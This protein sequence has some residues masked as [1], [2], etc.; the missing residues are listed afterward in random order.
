MACS[1]PE[2]LVPSTLNR[3]MKLAAVFLF[4]VVGAVGSIK[5]WSHLNSQ[6]STDDA[7]IDGHIHPVNARVSGTIVWVNPKVDDTRFVEAGTVLARLDNNDYTPSVDRLKGNVEAGEAQLESAKLALPI[8]RAAALSRFSSAQAAILEAQSDLASA[9]AGEQA[10]EALVVQ[11][12]ASFLRAESDRTR[13]EQLVSAHEISRS[14]YDQRRTDSKVFG[15]QFAAAKS[16]LAA[17]SQKIQAAEQHIAE[18]EGDLQAAATAPEVIATSQSS[19]NRVA[20]ELKRDEAS[21]HDAELN[22]SYTE[23]LAPV[24]GIVGRKQIEAGQRIAAGQLLLNLVPTNDLW[25]IANFKETQLRHMAIGSPAKI[26]VDSYGSVLDGTVE[27][28]G[29]ATGSKYSLIAPEN[30]TGNYVKV[31]QRIPVRIHITTPLDSL[32]PML[33]GMSVEVSVQRQ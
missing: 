4:L 25:V 6:I 8:T 30:A 22:L 17:A 31:L 23:I 5:A 20:G 3:T 19:V 32:H 16:S 24:S 15:A 7:Q 1:T 14:E 29:G 21:L 9:K 10:A 28:I 18:R 26:H 11:T 12:E 13:Y 33:P 2:D 27:S